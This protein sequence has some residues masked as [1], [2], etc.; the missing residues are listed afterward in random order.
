VATEPRQGDR[1]H[2]RHRDRPQ[3]PARRLLEMDRRNH[4]RTAMHHRVYR[5]D[6]GKR[7]VV[8][9]KDWSEKIIE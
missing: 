7:S 5:W 8:R 2:E 6:S 4:F 9:V 3:G 1:G